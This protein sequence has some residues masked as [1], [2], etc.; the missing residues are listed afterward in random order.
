MSKLANID[1]KAR[2]GQ[3][4]VVSPFVTIEEDVIIGDR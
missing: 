3:G 4:T 1:P 2:I